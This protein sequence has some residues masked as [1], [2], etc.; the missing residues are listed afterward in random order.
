M[1]HH[2]RADVVYVPVTDAEPAVISLAWLPG[3]PNP[4]AEA[5]RQVARTIAD[6]EPYPAVAVTS[7]GRA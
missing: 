4:D 7:A 2:P 3:R 1:A 6:Q 5:F